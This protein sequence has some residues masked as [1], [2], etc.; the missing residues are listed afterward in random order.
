MAS[1]T[2]PTLDDSRAPADRVTHSPWPTSK[3]AL[4]YVLMTLLAIA[5]IW[6]I[7]RQVHHSNRHAPPSNSR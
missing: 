5:S 2:T 7:D 6:Y 4:A 3:A 1:S